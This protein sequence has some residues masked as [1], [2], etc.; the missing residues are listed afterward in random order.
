MFP[1]DIKSWFM[2]SKSVKIDTASSADIQMLE[3]TIDVEL[4][5]ILKLLLLETNGSLWFMDKKAMNT[6]RI[7]EVV[8]N[9]EG[10]PNRQVFLEQLQKLRSSLFLL[11]S[12]Y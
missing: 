4:P 9:L 6:Q 2:R 12:L 7:Q 5:K 3:K 1:L 8:S 11:Y 10:S